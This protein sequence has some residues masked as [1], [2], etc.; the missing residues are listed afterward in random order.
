MKEIEKQI[1][2]EDKILNNEVTNSKAILVGP[3]K[4]SDY[5]L[6]NGFIIG[7]NPTNSDVIIKKSDAFNNLCNTGK[8]LYNILAPDV[9][10]NYEKSKKELE[11]KESE[12]I[13]K[14]IK[15]SDSTQQYYTNNFIEKFIPNAL[16]VNQ[17]INEI[18]LEYCKVNGLPD[19]NEIGFD[20][21][22]NTHVKVNSSNLKHFVS[23]SILTYIIF[24]IQLNIRE[25]LDLV[26]LNADLSSIKSTYKDELY[27]IN[28]YR[29]NLIPLLWFL[30]YKV[31]NNSDFEK[32]SLIDLCNSLSKKINIIQMNT[33][34]FQNLSTIN[35]SIGNL[36]F[37]YFESYTNVYAFCWDYLKQLMF[38]HT[39]Y[40]TK[41]C[42]KCKT[43]FEAESTA[44]YYCSNCIND[45]IKINSQNSYNRLKNLHITL[46]SLF[47]DA[48]LKKINSDDLKNIKLYCSFNLTELKKY[49]NPNKMKDLQKYIEI[50]KNVK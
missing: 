10:L 30:D 3:N 17:S 24:N 28:E 29:D 25:M 7:L 38:P 46:C 23:L 13:P 40:Y 34:Y 35:F 41:I 11:L 42:K 22:D 12:E 27:T 26:K 8:K 18:I 2:T 21:D 48:N 9:I 43:I 6:A 37:I 36:Q 4:F 49:K 47:K 44:T 15:I 1:V 33:A 14:F 16:L 5:T 45:R 19:F 50:L 20:E 39:G 31:E 32:L